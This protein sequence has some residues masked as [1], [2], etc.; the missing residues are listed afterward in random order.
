MD[1]FSLNMTLDRIRAHH[2]I[3]LK[4]TW[5]MGTLQVIMSAKIPS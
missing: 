5:S 1:H 3:L 4:I 2:L